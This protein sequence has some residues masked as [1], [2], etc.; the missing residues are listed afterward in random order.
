M[1]ESV[2][3]LLKERERALERQEGEVIGNWEDVG[4]KEWEQKYR[5]ITTCQDIVQ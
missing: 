4:L 5:L 2:G 3:R 1:I